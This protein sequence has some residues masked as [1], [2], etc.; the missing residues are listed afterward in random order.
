MFSWRK[1]HLQS[2]GVESSS[3]CLCERSGGFC[4]WASNGVEGVAG[5]CE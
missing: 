4:G 2:S 1:K 3:D 5:E